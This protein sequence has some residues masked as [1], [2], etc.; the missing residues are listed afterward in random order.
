MRKIF[1]V[2]LPFL[3]AACNS[4]GGV[5]RQGCTAGD[6]PD[7]IEKKSVQHYRIADNQY[8]RKGN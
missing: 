7:V 6:D 1:V 4:N 5:Q 3:L 2:A 8:C